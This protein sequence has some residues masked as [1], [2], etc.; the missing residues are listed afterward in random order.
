MEVADYNTTASSSSPKI[1]P[2]TDPEKSENEKMILTGA[3]KL[4]DE[5]I[6]A[7]PLAAMSVLIFIFLSKMFHPEGY[8]NGQKR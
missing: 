2:E 5:D 1:V 4:A 8:P 3:A 6:N 7:N